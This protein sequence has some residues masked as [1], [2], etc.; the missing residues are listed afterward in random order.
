MTTGAAGYGSVWPIA[1]LPLELEDDVVHARQCARI[2]AQ[3]LGFGGQDQTRIATALSEI[4]RNALDYAGGGKVDVLLAGAPDRC[5]VLRV[6]DRGPGIADLARIL[7]GRYESPTGMGRGI[8]GARRLMDRFAIDTSASGTTVD[9]AKLLPN[10]VQPTAA[11][12]RALSDAVRA[13]R[14]ANPGTV[15]R[16]ENRELVETLAILAEREE[17]AQRLN[18]ELEETNRGVVALHS[19]LERRAEELSRAGETLERQVTARTRELAEANTRLLAEAKARERIEADLRQ[20]QKM[21]AVGQL[22]GG[23]A[24]DFNNML[25]AI[26][27]ALDMVQRRLKQG[28]HERLDTYIEMA[29][30]SAS[31]AAALTHRL[32]AFARRQPLDPKVVDVNALVTGMTD[33]LR[34]TVNEAIELRFMLDPSVCT[35]L[36]DP[37]QLENAILNLAIN[38]RDA[39]PD[40]GCIEVATLNVIVAAASVTPAA[41]GEYVVV[42]VTDTGI[43]MPPEVAARAFDPFFTTKP[44]GQ[45]TGLGLSMIYGFARQSNGCAVI[46]SVPG[47]GTA[48]DI[49]LPR[50]DGEVATLQA[51][52]GDLAVADGRGEVVLLVEDENSIRDLMREAFADAGYAVLSARDGAEGLA[53]ARSAPQVDLLVT[54]VGLPGLNG[55]QLAD[56]VREFRPALKVLFITGYAE[57]VAS[58]SGFLEPGMA[59]LTKPF[60]VGTVLA[61]M[62]A[63]LNER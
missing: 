43:G 1:T 18:R 24:H 44:I 57:G 32:L 36:C 58:P 39:M 17:E 21:E 55:R 34:R 6:R 7:D 42:R 49:L 54:D 23:I 9:L 13:L 29:L 37:F 47:Q 2:V 45:G 40:G 61:R 16:D 60:D 56:A 62:R 15:V 14:S 26:V 28:R 63:M 41:P 52:A 20:S 25:G 5:L 31:R 11:S 19:E 48:I 59:I 8:T 10:G 53:V 51:S 33:L 46:T 30:S 3:H 50:H 22:T 12:V 4:A 27:G 38:A 35:T